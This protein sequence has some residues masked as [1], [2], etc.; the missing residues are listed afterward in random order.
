MKY[1]EVEGALEQVERQAT[2]DVTVG[3]L[4]SDPVN[5]LRCDVLWTG[6]QVMLIDRS[7]MRRSPIRLL[8][9]VAVLAT[10]LC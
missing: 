3:N 8:A 2:S 10:L 1:L 4:R 6:A 9:C 7:P 5:D